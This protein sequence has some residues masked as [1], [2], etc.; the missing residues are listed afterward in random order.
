MRGL[1]FYLRLA[2]Q[3]IGKNGRVYVVSALYQF[4][5]VAAAQE[6]VWPL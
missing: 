1:G 6:R 5:S 3:G 4:F 2:G